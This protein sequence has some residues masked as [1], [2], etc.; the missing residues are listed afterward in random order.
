VLVA[1]VHVTQEAHS[2]IC[3][4]PAEWRASACCASLSRS[5]LY[6]GPVL[7]TRLCGNRVPRHAKSGVVYLD[8]S[9]DGFRRTRFGGLRR[10]GIGFFALDLLQ[11]EMTG[12]VGED[13]A[14]SPAVRKAPDGARVASP[15]SPILRW[16][17]EAVSRFR[18]PVGL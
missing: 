12:R 7:D 15:Q 3:Y 18:S 1:N 10:R 11:Q 8:L 16:S 5:I 13:L 14:R 9:G 6:S 2:A 4:K 17:K